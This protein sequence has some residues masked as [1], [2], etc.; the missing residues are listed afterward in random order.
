MNLCVGCHETL[1]PSGTC[2]ESRIGLGPFLALA[3][4]R[5]ADLIQALPRDRVGRVEPDD[6]F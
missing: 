3:V 1:E 4:L 5:A 2:S 6:R